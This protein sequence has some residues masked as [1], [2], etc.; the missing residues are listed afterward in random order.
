MSEKI[1]IYEKYKCWRF[2][3][4]AFSIMVTFSSGTKVFVAVVKLQINKRGFN[5][6]NLKVSGYCA[7]H[8]QVFQACEY[9]DKNNL[10]GLNFSNAANV[11]KSSKGCEKW[12]MYNFL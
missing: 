3:S 12:H 4:H 7:L 1:V 11:W 9:H 10:M 5:Y 2:A 6:F 8:L